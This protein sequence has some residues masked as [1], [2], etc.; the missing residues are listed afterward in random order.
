M[1]SLPTTSRRTFICGHHLHLFFILS[2]FLLIISLLS[3]VAGSVDGHSNYVSDNCDW[4]GSGNLGADSERSVVPIYLRCSSGELV[5]ISIFEDNFKHFYIILGTIHW[6]WPKGGLRVVLRLGG[7]QKNS[8][9]FRGCIRVSRNSTTNGVRIYLEGKRQLHQI[10][11]ADDGKHPDLVRCFVSVHSLM[12]LFIETDPSVANSGGDHQL[13]HVKDIKDHIELSYDLTPMNFD[14]K[15][16]IEDEELSSCKPCSPSQTLSL[17]CSADF[18]LSGKV[19]YYHHRPEVEL[20][21]FHVT[22]T[23][24][25][26]YPVVSTGGA[27]LNDYNVSSSSDKQ[28]DQQIGPLRLSRPLKCA[29]QAAPRTEYLFIGRKVLGNYLI[30]CS[31]KLTEWREISRRALAEGTNQCHFFWRLTLSAKQNFSQRRPTAEEK[32]QLKSTIEKS[33]PNKR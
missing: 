30:S 7:I 26:R 21:S 20:T 2:S 23:Y 5:L 28:N 18:V 25:H 14:N 17:F 11:A 8:G 10:Y 4:A 3:A 24:V 12:A 32:S 15:A 29:S 31:P 16:E 9:D 1:A 27:Y 13:H 33:R 22:P 6:L 19:T